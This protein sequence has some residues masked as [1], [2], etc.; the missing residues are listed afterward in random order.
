MSA[1]PEQVR[2]PEQQRHGQQHPMVIQDCNGPPLRA[3]RRC[4]VDLG[5]LRVQER[6]SGRCLNIQGASTANGALLQL[7]DC[8]TTIGTN[9][10]FSVQ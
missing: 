3:T 7:Y 6:A 2:R 10:Q 4:D 8:G 5:R 9:A 1:E